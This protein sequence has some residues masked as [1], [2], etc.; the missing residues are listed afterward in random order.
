MRKIKVAFIFKTSNPF[1]SGKHFDN[2][3]YNFHVNA[4]K[5]NNDIEISYFHGEE[6]FDTTVLRD[7]FDIILLWSNCT[8]GMPKELIGIQE[9]DI[10]VISGVSDPV[11]AKDSIRLH[12]K[13]KIDY[14]YHFTHEDFFYEL[15]PRD[16]KYR[17]IVMGVETSIYK[18]VRS[19]N[20]RIKNKILLTGAIGNK[21]ILSR[22]LNDIKRP[23]WNAYRFY[24]LRT[25]CS[26]LSY[27]DY[28]STLQHEYVNDR[29]PKLLEKYAA[30]IAATTYTPNMKYW[31][32]AA[33]GCLTFMEVTEKNRGEH[34]GYKDGETAIFIDKD[35]FEERFNRF[36]KE[37]DNPKWEKIAREGRKFTLENLS[38]DNAATKLVE[39][40]KELI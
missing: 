40:M 30:S 34:L 17:K 37:P 10:P 36:L 2:S 21:K 32:N 20:D 1:M 22:V 18:N 23:K 26:D 29:Y 14:Y 16:F 4:L 11:D 31:E 12:K 38:N 24:Y 28:T 15:Y 7:N 35:N 5:R 8:F 13:W 33:A 3:W 39:L 6:E 27:V 9:L 25:K 19:F